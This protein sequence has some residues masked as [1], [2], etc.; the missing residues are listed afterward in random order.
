[1]LIRP[2]RSGAAAAA[3][4][5]AASD[6]SPDST[7]PAVATEEGENG[8][9]VAKTTSF[10]QV[11][12]K[13]ETIETKET[14]ATPSKQIPPLQLLKDPRYFLILPY[15]ACHFGAFV[16]GIVYQPSWAALNGIDDDNVSETKVLHMLR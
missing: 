14:N 13:D 15:M 3:K 4:S 12:M 11:S 16:T 2:F 6:A 5:A 1:M 9:I 7:I 10:I 8:E